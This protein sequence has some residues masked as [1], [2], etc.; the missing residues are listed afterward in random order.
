MKWHVNRLMAVWGMAFGIAATLMG[1][2]VLRAAQGGYLAETFFLIVI[3]WVLI[4]VTVAKLTSKL[5]EMRDN[6]ER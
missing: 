4:L 5:M 1:M 2:F 3:G 6:H